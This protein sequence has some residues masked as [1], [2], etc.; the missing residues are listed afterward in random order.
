MAEDRQQ[1]VKT[2][3]CLR[4]ILVQ[5][6]VT[7]GTQMSTNCHVLAIPLHYGSQ[8][9][10]M[11]P[12]FSLHPSG[13]QHTY[14]CHWFFLHHWNY[15]RVVVT[16]HNNCVKIIGKILEVAFRLTNWNFS[17]R[18]EGVGPGRR[19]RSC[20]DLSRFPSHFGTPL[21]GAWFHSQPGPSTARR[22]LDVLGSFEFEWWFFKW[23]DMIL[24]VSSLCP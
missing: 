19:P 17:S 16:I 22:E 6:C 1:F 15:C 7:M 20:I 9:A 21:T 5:K 23:H 18:S 12:Y 24:F 3:F 2:I 13:V 10:F 8:N 14:Q 11:R 4:T